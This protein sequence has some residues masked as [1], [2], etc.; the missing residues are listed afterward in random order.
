MRHILGDKIRLPIWSC[1]ICEGKLKVVSPCP[2]CVKKLKRIHFPALNFQSGGSKSGGSKI[3]GLQ[4]GDGRSGHLALFAYDRV[5]RKLIHGIKYKNHI[6]CIGWVAEQMAKLINGHRY[7]RGADYI[8]WVPASIQKKDR[9]YD[10]A[11]LLAEALSSKVEI[12][13]KG[14]LKRHDDKSQTSRGKTNRDDRLSGPELSARLRAEIALGDTLR[15]SQRN[16]QKNFRQNPTQNSKRNPK[17]VILIDDVITTGTSINKARL[18]LESVGAERVST[19]A[20]C[21]TILRKQIV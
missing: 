12:A 6:G 19:L 15:N 17:H 8:T 13:A 3:N 2:A 7:L 4:I 10:Q 11:K 5:G 1:P 14:F 21:A 16:S 18:I 9:G 20:V